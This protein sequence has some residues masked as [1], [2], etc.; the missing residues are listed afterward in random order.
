M[1]L[2]WN[3]QRY[4]TRDR[5]YNV[6]GLDGLPTFLEPTIA[7]IP[8]YSNSHLNLLEKEIF[9]IARQ[10]GFMGDNNSFWQKFSAGNVHVLPT[11]LDFP[12]QG[13]IGDLY[14]DQETDILYY[15]KSTTQIVYSDQAAR[16]GA[17]IVGTHIIQNT[18]TTITYLYIPV[19]ALPIE[20]LIYDCGDAAEY[21]G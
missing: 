9:E 2:D 4:R 11:I 13:I 19:R 17:A 16:I 7:P 10:N 12:I 1:R 8:L 14:L 6:Q 3:R 15:F 18:T 20:N 21:I 5:L